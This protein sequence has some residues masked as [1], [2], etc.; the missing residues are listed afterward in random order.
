[1]KSLTTLVLLLFAAVPAMAELDPN[2]PADAMTI[3][4]KVA[5]STVDG[6]AVTYAWHGN[7]WVRRA[8]ERDR[9]LFRIEGM[10]VRA[11]STVSDPKRGSGYKLVSREIMLYK[12]PKT[13]EVL[14]TWDNPW[15]GKTNTVMHVANDPVNFAQYEVGR[16]GQ[17]ARWRG[18]IEGD[19]YR[20]T[21][22]VPLFYTNPLGGE[23][24]KEVGGTYHATEMF[25]FFG[26]AGALLDPDTT[27]VMPHVGWVRMSTWLPWMEMN[28]RDGLLY[29]HAS[30][31]KLE[32]WD[33]LSD[34]MKAEIEQHYPDYVDPPPLDDE[35]RNE[36]SWIYYQRVQSGE[37]ELPGRD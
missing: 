3:S 34:T 9:L 8:G 1:M 22:T 13:D 15:T 20:Q 33:E 28:G 19:L 32:S 25:N 10:N 24:Q 7:L 31:R 27:T 35:R 5:C 23:F 16:D 17:P 11:C 18:V 14:N 6:E 30:G 36:T 4:R 29:V 37:R 12:D 26:D 21:N 2:D